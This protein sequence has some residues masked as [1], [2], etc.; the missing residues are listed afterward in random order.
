MR[1]TLNQTHIEGLLYQHSLEL[2]ES[3]PN[4]KNPGTQF[5]SGVVE[6]ATDNNLTN[7]VPV[8]FTYVTAKTASGK[9]NAAFNTLSNIIDGVIPNVMKDGKDRAAT[10]KID[11]AIGLNEFY[12][13]RNG[14]MELVSVKRNEGGFVHVGGALNEDEAA[15]STFKADMLITGCNRIEGD[16]ERQ[17]VDKV[18]VKGA[19]FDF[20]GGLLPVS[21]SI[22]D[23]A[24]MA[25]FEGL[26]AS[27]KEPVFTQLW[28]NQVSE[29]IVRTYTTESAFGAD[30]VRT[31]SSTRKDFIITGAAKEPYT[32]DSEEDLTAQELTQ[33]MADRETYLATIKKRQDEYNASKKSAPAAAATPAAAPGGFNF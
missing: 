31:V 5:I 29:T 13:D 23:P 7:I 22:T 24:G 2:K 25:Y 33:K 4:S 15:R 30:S 32:W 28:G 26:N 9:N 27:N 18:E 3:G 10:I 19:I 17:T 1:K 14:E 16:P 11:S 20:R 21:F 6:V 12:S 8:H